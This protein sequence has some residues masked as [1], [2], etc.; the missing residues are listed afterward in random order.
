[1]RGQKPAAEFV[2]FLLPPLGG[3]G[4]ARQFGPQGS[5]IRE[6]NAASNSWPAED[7]KLQSLSMIAATRSLP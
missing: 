1:M 5:D 6:S 7:D 3:L 4:I 2:E